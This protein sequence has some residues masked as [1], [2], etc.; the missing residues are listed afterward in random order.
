VLHALNDIIVH[1]CTSAVSKQPSGA[2]ASAKLAAA[3]KISQY[4][5]ILLLLCFSQLCWKLWIQS[6]SQQFSLFRV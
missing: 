3:R 6:S 4:A 2:G 5:D 1:D